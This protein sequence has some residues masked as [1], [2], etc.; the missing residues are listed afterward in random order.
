MTEAERFKRRQERLRA[1]EQRIDEEYDKKERLNA[2]K[3]WGIQVSPEDIGSMTVAELEAAASRVAAA[4]EVLREAGAW[5]P[6]ADSRLQAAGPADL[7]ELHW[8]G[9]GGATEVIYPAQGLAQTA[10]QRP[11][12]PAV[13][14]SPSE[15]A[16]RERLLKANRPEFPPEIESAEGT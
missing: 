1:R 12:A 5:K 4:L 11:P 15:L 14:W 9:P 10:P 6:A 16:E 8:S 3:R 13:R 2:K 7:R